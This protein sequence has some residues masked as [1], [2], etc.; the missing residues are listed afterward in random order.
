MSEEKCFR[1]SIGGQALI[2]GILMRG[3]EKQAVVVRKPDGALEKKVE[4]RKLVSK[5]Y[6]ILSWPLIR[7]AVGLISSLTV[8]V[9]ALT[10]SA[11][12]LPEEEQG[13]LTGLDK[14]IADHFEEKKANDIITGLA[15]VLGALLAVGLFVFLPTLLAG[16]LEPWIGSGFWLSLTEG[17]LR[18]ALFLG[19]MML[20]SRMKEIHRVWQYHGAEHKSIHCY[21]KGLPL[22][23]ENCRIQPREHPRCGTSFLFIVLFLSILVFSLVNLPG[24]DLPRIL[25]ILARMG[26]K[27]ALLPVVVGLAYEVIKY[28]GGHDNLFSRIVSAP[29]KALQ[30]LTTAEPEDEMLEVAIAALTEVLPEEKGSDVW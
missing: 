20:V 1:T 18:I 6:R 27:L 5:K 19:Y 12:F 13:E 15:V 11:G 29:G 26:L 21:E 25:R 7:G 9:K 22:T 17:L 10:W 8:G 16:L 2:E 24:S 3:P 28:V 30:K 4:P 14:W 23:V